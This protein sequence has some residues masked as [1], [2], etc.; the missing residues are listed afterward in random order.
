MNHADANKGGIFTSSSVQAL[1]RLLRNSRC[2]HS[3]A[4]PTQR[5]RAFVSPDWNAPEDATSNSTNEAAPAPQKAAAHTMFP[6]RRFLV[7]PRNTFFLKPQRN[8]I[9]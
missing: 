8:E 3:E 2:P 9:C 5:R 7:S 1:R 4:V 6:P